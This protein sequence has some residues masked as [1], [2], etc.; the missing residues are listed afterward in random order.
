MLASPAAIQP[1]PMQRSNVELCAAVKPPCSGVNSHSARIAP[2]SSVSAACS[3][4]LLPRCA[5][6]AAGRSASVRHR[7]NTPLVGQWRCVPPPIGNCLKNRGQTNPASTRA[8]PTMHP[9]AHQSIGHM[10]LGPRAG[11][12][13]VLRVRRRRWQTPTDEVTMPPC[14]STALASVRRRAGSSLNSP[15]RADL[16]PRATATKRNQLSKRSLSRCQPCPSGSRMKSVTTGVR[17]PRAPAGAVARCVTFREKHPA[18][19]YRP[20]AGAQPV[21][22]PLRSTAGTHS[23]LDHYHSASSTPN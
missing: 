15:V 14:A 3:A 10:A 21:A 8:R 2:T 13:A 7:E 9:A 4:S 12:R 16:A 19:P 6:R 20:A 18:G 22:M 23:T 17:A 1:S 5:I 11:E